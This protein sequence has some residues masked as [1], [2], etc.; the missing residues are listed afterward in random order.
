MKFHIYYF[1]KTA[2]HMAVENG[3]TEISQLLL[4]HQSIN[5]NVVCVLISIIS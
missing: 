5:V 2:L 1:Y 4:K 3:N